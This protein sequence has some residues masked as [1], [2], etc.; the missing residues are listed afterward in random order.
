MSR[1]LSILQPQVIFAFG[2]RATDALLHRSTPLAALHG[3][4]IKSE[5]GLRVIPLMHPSTINIAGMRR[6][7]IT[8]LDDY[9][10]KLAALF[11]REWDRL[12]MDLSP[13]LERGR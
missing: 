6:V 4:V 2:K 3:Q 9:E 1:E 8:S 7:G 5:G 13:K 10:V 12:T 11:R